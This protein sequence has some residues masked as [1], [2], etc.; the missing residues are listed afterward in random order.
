MAMN[1]RTRR[2][3][4]RQGEMA[5]DGTPVGNRDRR[6]AV[7]AQK[8]ESRRSNPRQFL[9]EVRTELS[10]VNWP[11][12]SEVVN[13]SIVVFITIVVLTAIIAG[14]DYLLGEAVLNL[15]DVI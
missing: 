3:L 13:Y 14:L 5:E 1:R 15:F 9:R 12:R 10:K 11:T 2:H 6:P 4:Q 8:E 7:N